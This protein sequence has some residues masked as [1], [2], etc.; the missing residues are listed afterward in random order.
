MS[1][2]QTDKL[3][4]RL[5]DRPIA[6]TELK[7]LEAHAEICPPCRREI[8]S[9]QKMQRLL[10]EGLNPTT[11][12]AEARDRVLSKLDHSPILAK[13]VK[14]RWPARLGLPTP[15]AAG[16]LLALGVA[17]GL[18]LGR[19]RPGAPQTQSAATTSRQTPGAPPAVTPIRVCGVAGTVLIKHPG[20][21]IWEE[22][23]ESTPICVGDR[24][25]ASPAS[26]LALALKDGNTVCLEANGTLSLEDFNGQ[27][28]FRVNFGTVTADL[29]SPHGPFFIS[30]PQGRIEALGTE[31]T[32]SVR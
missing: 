31:F 24:F 30:T 21:N 20:A 8:D 29:K 6:D 26:S 10:T 9:F 18:G 11:S 15:V 14:F 16:I 27:I 13:G 7:T 22:V 28:E 1:C 2:N 19:S 23:A 25:H 12:G 32:V 3:L 4:E 17:I 5:L